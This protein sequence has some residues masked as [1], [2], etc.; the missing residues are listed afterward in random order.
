MMETRLSKS[1]WCVVETAEVCVFC[2]FSLLCRVSV[3]MCFS[4]LIARNVLILSFVL[5]LWAAVGAFRPA[6]CELLL[7]VIADCWSKIK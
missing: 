1:Y 4:R 5:S 3:C 6:H 7:L 2:F